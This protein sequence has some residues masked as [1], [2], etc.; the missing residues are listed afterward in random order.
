MPHKLGK[1][2][3]PWCESISKTCRKHSVFSFI[4]LKSALLRSIKTILV[5]SRWASFEFVL[6]GI[7]TFRKAFRHDNLATDLVSSTFAIIDLLGQYADLF[8]VPFEDPL[9]TNL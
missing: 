4:N 6:N 8:F 3:R 7:G 5:L 2:S 1:L 9:F